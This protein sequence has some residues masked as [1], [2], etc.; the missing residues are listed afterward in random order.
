MADLEGNIGAKDYGLDRPQKSEA[1]HVKG[2]N[3]LDFGMKHRLARF[4]KSD[5]RTVMPVSY[6]HLTLPTIYSV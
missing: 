5:G 3:Q 4:F 1:F 2:A 6:T